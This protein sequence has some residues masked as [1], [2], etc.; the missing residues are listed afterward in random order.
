MTPREQREAD[1]TSFIKLSEM[2]FI[3]LMDILTRHSS[4]TL[5]RSNRQSLQ[6]LETK[7]NV[8][9][10]RLLEVTGEIIKTLADT[11][12]A[13]LNVLTSLLQQ[14]T[15]QKAI[16]LNSVIIGKCFVADY[17]ILNTIRWDIEEARALARAGQGRIF[18][19]AERLNATVKM[20]QLHTEI[21][22]L[23]LKV[24]QE[25]IKMMDLGQQADNVINILS[26]RD[27]KF[28]DHINSVKSQVKERLNR[29]EKDGKWPDQK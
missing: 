18:S 17:R 29:M 9:L 10:K 15:E 19:T 22:Q 12:V 4:V 21:S 23:E 5:D 6:E 24:A 2:Q 7:D 16:T 1:P 20:S 8:Y 14:L 28:K 11:E 25:S 27:Y 13:N 3:M 26:T